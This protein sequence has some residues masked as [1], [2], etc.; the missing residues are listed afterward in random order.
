MNLKKKRWLFLDTAPTANIQL[1]F[2]DDWNHEVQPNSV[3]LLT[4]SNK[5][6]QLP[7]VYTYEEVVITLI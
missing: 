1:D 7:T 5:I 3:P 4:N 2:E 6:H